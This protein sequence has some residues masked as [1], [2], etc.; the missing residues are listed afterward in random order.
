MATLTIKNIPNRL[1]G[2]LKQNAKRHRRSVNSEV[3]V[4]LERVLTQPAVDPEEFLERVRALRERTPHFF[5]RAAELN[6]AKKWGRP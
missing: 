4:Y 3:I 1:Y 6:K 5:V 2:R